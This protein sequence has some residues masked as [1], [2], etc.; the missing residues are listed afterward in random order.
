LVEIARDW[1]DPYPAGNGCTAWV[2]GRRA[3]QRAAKLT[4]RQW[5][6]GVVVV[7]TSDGV[8][9]TVMHSTRKW[10]KSFLPH[11]DLRP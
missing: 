1:G 7:E 3:A 4:G 5:R 6:S 2:L 11:R 9:L 8:V 10:K